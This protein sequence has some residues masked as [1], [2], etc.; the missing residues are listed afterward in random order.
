MLWC[1]EGQ[2]TNVEC[3]RSLDSLLVSFG[4][5]LGMPVIV[6]AGWLEILVQSYRRFHLINYNKLFGFLAPS[7]FNVQTPQ[8]GTLLAFYWLN[9][10]TELITAKR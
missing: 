9:D 6:F 4:G 7:N 5:Q 3:G 10:N 2:V 8:I 1:E